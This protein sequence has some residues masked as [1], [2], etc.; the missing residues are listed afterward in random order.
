MKNARQDTDHMAAILVFVAAVAFAASPFL[1]SGFNGFEGEQF[2]VPQIDPPITP[3]GY[4]FGIWGLIYL[5]LLVHAGVGLVRRGESAAWRP[6]R[7]PLFASLAVGAAWIPAANT[8][9]AVAT[10]MIWVMLVTA[11]LALLRTSEA[12]RWLLQAPVAI[13]AGWLTAAACVALAL[14]GAGYG[15]A[16]GSGLWGVIGLGLALVIAV[17]V[18]ALIGRA[19]EY[20]ITV[21]WALVA[22]AL[23]NW[24]GAWI[25]VALAGLGIAVMAYLAI[26]AATA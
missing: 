3:A 24:G 9:P 10:G 14:S 8:S 19:P 6:V 15:L 12:D 22:I 25:M 1:T 23:A 26:R 20:G 4:A 16:F 18:Q 21:I 2:P 13:Y 7:W 5:W 11:L 17:T